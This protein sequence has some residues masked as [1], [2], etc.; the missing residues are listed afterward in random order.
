MMFKKDKETLLAEIRCNSENAIHNHL[1]NSLGPGMAMTNGSMVNTIQV[2]ISMA[3]E[4]AFRTMLEARYTDDDFDK[5]I[6][7]KP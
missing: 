3:I 4:E 2:A 6:G 5:D 7:L 1:Y